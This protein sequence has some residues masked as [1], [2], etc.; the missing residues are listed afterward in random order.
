[1]LPDFL[2]IT[3]QIFIYSSKISNKQIRRYASD[4]N[5]MFYKHAARD[6]DVRDV[7]IKVYREN[8]STKYPTGILTK[9]K[10]FFN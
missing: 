10:L 2:F 5:A 1:M 3:I 6:N 8:K 9:T 4:P 7:L